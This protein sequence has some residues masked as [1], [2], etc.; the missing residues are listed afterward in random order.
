MTGFEYTVSDEQ[1]EA[2]GRSTL[3]AR[4]AWLEGVR[5]MTWALASDDTRASWDRLRGRAPVP[6]PVPLVLQGEV[7]ARFWLGDADVFG[8]APRG[9]HERRV[10]AGRTGVEARALSVEWARHLGPR[11]SFGL[12]GGSWAPSSDGLLVVRVH[13]GSSDGPAWPG[14]LLP[15]GDGT[16]IGLPAWAAQAILE[17]ASYALALG[18]GVLDIHRAAHDDVASSALAFAATFRAL[19]EGLGAPRECLADALSKSLN[20]GTG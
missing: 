12:L 10:S 3:D 5:T 4:L 6:L 1:L 7:K 15:V 11:F 20:E 8:Y 19:V 17:H 9:V 14:T 16:R 2:Y 13:E 18:S